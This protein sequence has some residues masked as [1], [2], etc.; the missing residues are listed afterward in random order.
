[1]ASH[2]ATFSRERYRDELAAVLAA[3][4]QE[5]TAGTGHRD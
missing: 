1:M 5:H 3:A 2:A 4:W